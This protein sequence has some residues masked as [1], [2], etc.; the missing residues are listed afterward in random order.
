MFHYE[1]QEKDDNQVYDLYIKTKNIFRFERNKG[2]IEY[3]RHCLIKRA[4]FFTDN[5]RMFIVRIHKEKI[6][7]NR[8]KVSPLT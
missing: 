7:K 1:L 5:K 4:D 3:F 6:E 8:F 2:K